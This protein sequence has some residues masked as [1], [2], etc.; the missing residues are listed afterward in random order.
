MY[1]WLAYVHVCNQLGTPTV[2]WEVSG[3][4]V[5]LLCRQTAISQLPEVSLMRVEKSQSCQKSRTHSWCRGKLTT[6]LRYAELSE[7]SAHVFVASIVHTWCVQ[8]QLCK[9]GNGTETREIFS[10]DLHEWIIEQILQIEYPKMRISTQFRLCKFCHFWLHYSTL[11]VVILRLSWKTIQR[12]LNLVLKRWKFLRGAKIHS[13]ECALGQS[14]WE[15]GKNHPVNAESGP[16]HLD[17]S[18]L[19]TTICADCFTCNVHRKMTSKWRKLLRISLAACFRKEPSGSFNVINL[20]LC[21]PCNSDIRDKKSQ[22]ETLEPIGTYQRLR[23]DPMDRWRNLPGVRTVGK[24]VTA[25]W[26]F[27]IVDYIIREW[28]LHAHSDDDEWKLVV[29]G[30]LWFWLR[31]TGNRQKL[32]I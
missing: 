24:V 19:L 13:Y 1:Y 18:S 10:E 30:F 23:I 21:G 12:R 3:D 8:E 16:F 9:H 20:C 6:G 27:Y 2:R 29:L 31:Y 7:S 14:W 15:H 22:H 32:H 26:N 11:N 4:L 28:K 25:T 5:G 17:D